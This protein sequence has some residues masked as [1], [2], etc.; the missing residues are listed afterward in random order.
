M[1]KDE[2]ERY[3]RPVRD[4]VLFR[5][6]FDRH[7]MPSRARAIK[8][9]LGRDPFID[10]NNMEL[11]DKLRAQLIGLAGPHAEVFLKIILIKQVANDQ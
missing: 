7:N 8:S 10:A 1:T 11:D 9:L 6:M 3:W 4:G 5:N 2:I